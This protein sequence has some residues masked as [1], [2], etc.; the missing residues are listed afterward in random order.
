MASINKTYSFLDVNATLQGPGGTYS[1]SENGIANEGIT[2][3]TN[4]RVTTVYGADGEWM[5]SL[6][7]ARG[8]RVTIRALRTGLINAFLSQLF[9]FDTSSSANTGQNLITVTDLLRGDD[10]TIFGAA[11]VKLP[12]NTY[13]TEGGIVE[14]QFNAG[15]IHGAFGVGRPDANG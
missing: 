14:W 4:E 8:G 11:L 15:D 6:H 12:T 2:I 7:A 10:W 5:H 1:L 13:A 3:E 9:A